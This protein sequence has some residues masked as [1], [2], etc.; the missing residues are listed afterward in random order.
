VGDAVPEEH[1]AARAALALGDGSAHADPIIRGH[2]ALCEEC[3]AAASG[4][5]ELTLRTEETLRA[6]L[7]EVSAPPGMTGQLVAALRREPR[8]TLRGALTSPWALRALVPLAV[9]LVIGALVW[10]RPVA[11]PRG[12]AT[13]EAV[14][15]DEATLARRALERLYTAPAGGGVWQGR[16]AMRWYFADASYADLEGQLWLDGE[17]GRHRVQLV[18]ED[19]GGPFELQLGDGDGAL[20]YSA[21]GRYA[22]S[23]YPQLAERWAQKVELR[24]TPD[25]QEAM[26]R[27]RLA[28][29]AWDLA[30]AYLRQ[31]VQAGDLRSW[32]RRTA[33]DGADLAVVSFSGASALGRPAGTSDRV[34]V[35]LSIDTS[36]GALYEVRELVGPDSGEQTGRTVWRFLGGERLG[37]AADIEEAFGRRGAFA[38]GNFAIR[39]AGAAA[40]ELPTVPGE[41][42]TPLARALR[43]QQQQPVIPAEAPPGATAAA[44]V[45]GEGGRSPGWTIVYLGPGRRMVISTILPTTSSGAPF[46][47]TVETEEVQLGSATALL[48]P[49]PVQRYEAFFGDVQDEY[50]VVYQA[51]VSSQ[52][53]SRDELLDVLRGLAPLSIEA[54]RSQSTL[55]LEPHADDPAAFS[56]LL[57]AL[58]LAP[59]PPAGSV[60]Y[61]VARVFVRQATDADPL[62]DPY[63]RPPYG[64]RPET[65]TVETWTR[66][67][68]RGHEMVSVT[69]GP[70]GA[71][72][73]RRYTGPD[74]GWAQDVSRGE[75]VVFD[76]PA[77][78]WPQSRGAQVAEQLLACGGVLTE[79][80]D[81]DRAVIFTELDWRRGSCALPEYPIMAEIQSVTY[82]RDGD[83]DSAFV[84]DLPDGALTTLVALGPDGRVTRSEVYAGERAEA[85]REVQVERWEQVSERVVPA[86][87]VPAEVFNPEPPAAFMRLAVGQG[88]EQPVFILAPID[89]AQ[90]RGV[91][92]GTLLTVAPEASDDTAGIGQV[93]LTGAVM[94]RFDPDGL[95]THIQR[96]ADPFEGALNYGVAVRLEF[97]LEGDAVG[98][99]LWR[100]LYQGRADRFGA[101]LRAQARWRASEPFE[102]AVDGEPVPG[103]KVTTF[104]GRA[105]LIADVDGLTVAMPLDTPEQL[106]LAGRLTRA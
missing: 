57:D 72:Y 34:T 32:G 38:S 7:R 52:G 97:E 15:V 82:T 37:R 71:V 19:G 62:R 18:H 45:S 3:R 64:G 16:Y 12:M 1:R 74:G 102:V 103:W 26:L 81:G 42:V 8:P 11:E 21:E 84:A 79:L 56:A 78:G 55:F 4:W 99:R 41:A 98:Q 9:L 22:A 20:W 10:P 5:R 58:A 105:W 17:R 89:L 68:G 92:G 43:F 70:D 33:G 29:G 27:A 88:G 95:Y 2:L 101:Y 104:D 76:D 93:G 49:G 73:E 67:A 100:P 86:E 77:K 69:H 90:V 14:A 28:S 51:H 44:L 87:R 60:N 83:V 50:G 39:P 61:S 47:R 36:S 85:P 63:H 66:A 91:L 25:E 46:L 80:P 59:A 31:A 96:F 94:S 6:V 24:L 13:E 40:P 54:V 65:V 48:Q 106:V 53:F 75:V 35:L 30:G 23:I